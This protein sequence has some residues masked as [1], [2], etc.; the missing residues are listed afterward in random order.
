MTVTPRWEWRTSADADVPAADRTD[1]ERALYLLSAGSDASVKIRDGVLDVKHLLAVAD[2]GLE[3]WVPV[4]KAPFPVAAGDVATVVETLQVAAPELTRRDYELGEL[5]A[6]VVEPTAGVRAVEVHKSRARFLAGGCTAERSVL[7]TAAGEVTMVAVED[8]DPERVRA[9]VG[10]LGLSGRRVICVA[11]GLKA[12]EGMGE[13]RFAVIDVGTNS[14]KLHVGERAADGSWRPVAD[15]AEVTRLGKGLGADGRLDPAAIE[16]TVA[17]VTA[18]AGEARGHRAEAVVAVGTAALRQAPNAQE[19]VEAA[20]A[21]A[22]V[23]VEVIAGDEEARLA[24]QAALAGLTAGDG[25]FVVFDTGGGS[26]QFSSG[27]AG[28]VEERFSVD[29]GAAAV[30]ERHGL[31]GPV[32]PEVV[33]AAQADIGARLPLGDRS[34]PDALI[35][36]GGAATNLAA[37]ELGLDAYDPDVVHGTVLTR[38]AIDRQIERYR[39]TDAEQRR[40]ITG[41]QPARA[42]VILAGACIVRAILS[43]LKR[44]SFSVSDRGL[45]H[46]VLT[47]RFALPRPMTTREAVHTG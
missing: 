25:T 24:A 1:Q 12:L 17:A 28:R 10:A 9:A 39:T 14:V 36:M 35:G 34:A 11:R 45:R 2:D 29:V 22:G 20:H 15:R 38:R 37:V 8:E 16:R 30:T 23:E 46:G 32:E 13:H 6:E 18:L 26:S 47:E 27:R 5:L 41:L 4:L 44:D 3:R 19:L 7:R 33:A 21:R 43:A 40:R 31:A 42:E